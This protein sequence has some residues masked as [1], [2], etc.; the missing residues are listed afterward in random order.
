MNLNAMSLRTASRRFRPR[1]GVRNR[2][3]LRTEVVA[4]ILLLASL[5]CF[6]APKNPPPSHRVDLNRATL[7]QLEKLPGIGPVRA[8]AIL[9][10][11]EQ[12]GPFHRVDDLLAIRGIGRSRLEKIRPYVFVQKEKSA[13]ASPIQPRSKPPVRPN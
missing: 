11:R 10:F 9:K 8:R 5:A 13:P 1:A 6:A 3:I 7:A 4:P 12:S 2:L